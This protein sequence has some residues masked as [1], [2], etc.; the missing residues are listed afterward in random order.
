MPQH[1]AR[2]AAAMIDRGRIDAVPMKVVVMSR[3]FA[4]D[5]PLIFL[6]NDV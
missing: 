3:E 4:L 1:A 5:R 6:V 2:K